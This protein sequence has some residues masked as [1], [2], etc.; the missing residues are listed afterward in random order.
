MITSS[1]ISTGSVHLFKSRYLGELG[2]PYVRDGAVLLSDA[3]LASCSAPTYFDP[4]H[5]DNY[6]LAD[7]GLWANNPSIIALVEAVSKFGQPIEQYESSPSVPATPPV[8]TVVTDSGAF[9]GGA[10]KSWSICFGSAITGLD[11]HV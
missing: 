10:V 5:V 4:V 6:L 8:S 7:G 3:I 1:D 11:E 9:L 2:E